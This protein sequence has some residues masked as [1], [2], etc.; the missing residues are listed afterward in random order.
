M[1]VQSSQQVTGP[2][3]M[4]LSS[5]KTNY[6]AP[7]EEKGQTELVAFAQPSVGYVY[8]ENPVVL[9][10]P[11][12]CPYSAPHNGSN[13]APHC[14]T[15]ALN[16]RAHGMA[17][18]HMASIRVFGWPS[19]KPPCVLPAL[20][21][22]NKLYTQIQAPIQQHL[23]DRTA[24]CQVPADPIYYAAARGSSRRQNLLFVS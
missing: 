15:A 24:V 4:H 7:H 1:Q 5:N 12:G 14:H 17:T 3:I 6:A 23:L 21:Q 10:G 11:E 19:A 20:F 2:C 9:W 16:H 8:W 18:V 13:I 22:P